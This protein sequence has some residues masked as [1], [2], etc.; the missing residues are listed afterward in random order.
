MNTAKPKYTRICLKISGEALAGQA[1]YGIDNSILS[2]IVGE[3]AAVHALGVEIALVVGGGNVIRGIS[4]SKE[5]ANRATADYM[6]M[7]ATVINSLAVQEALEK[8]GVPARVLTAL[9]VDEVAEPYLRRRA[10]RHLEKG[11]V[12]VFAAG[13][14]RPFFTTDTAAALRAAEID[15]QIVLKATKVDGV[16]SADPVTDADAVRYE[17]LTHMDVLQRG[18]KVMD[19]TAASLCMDNNIPIMVFNFFTPGNLLKAVMGEL[20]GTLV[21]TV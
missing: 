4:A 13:T 19:A 8:K 20:V 9:R 15:C 6:G 2:N 7:L 12:V 10:L 11:R 5:G 16:Y 3:I 1:G 17:Q 14:G 21:I 18:L